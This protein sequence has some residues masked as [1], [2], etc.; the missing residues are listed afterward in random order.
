MRRSFSNNTSW[1][2]R[3]CAVVLGLPSA[4]GTGVNV[5]TLLLST[6]GAWLGFGLVVHWLARWFGGQARVG[7]FLGVFGLAYAPLLLTVIG[8]VPGATV[9]VALLFF[10]MLITKFIAVKQAHRLSTGY[11]LAAILGAYLIW[12]LIFLAVAL[13][14]SGFG[15]EQAANNSE[16]THFLRSLPF[17]KP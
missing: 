3:A 6:F 17:A 15:I 5:T 14:G 4:L 16:V 2:G 9:P 12:L 13:F 7:Q 10:A 1:V 11:A 8:V